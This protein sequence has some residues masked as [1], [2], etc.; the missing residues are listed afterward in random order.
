MSKHIVDKAHAA[1]KE[2]R[3]VH[4]AKIEKAEKPSAASIALQR[5]AKNASSEERAKQYARIERNIEA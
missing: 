2:A 3:L 5:R 1:S 4:Y